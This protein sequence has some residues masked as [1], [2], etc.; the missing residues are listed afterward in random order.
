MIKVKDLTIGSFQ[1]II[2]LVYEDKPAN[3]EVVDSLK[4][5]KVF[6]GKSGQ[7]F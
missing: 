4:G 5:K 2:S 3:N 6:E 1:G 7:L